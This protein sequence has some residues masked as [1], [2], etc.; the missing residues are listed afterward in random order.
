[1][2]RSAANLFDPYLVSK[3]FSRVLALIISEITNFQVQSIRCLKKGDFSVECSAMFEL[4]K[5]VPCSS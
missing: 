5:R 4:K 3:Q 2:A 1:M